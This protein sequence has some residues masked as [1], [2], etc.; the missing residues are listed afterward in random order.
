MKRLN[1][2]MAALMVATLS[3]AACSKDAT[4]EKPGPEPGPEQPVEKELTFEAVV[5]ETTRTSAFINVT[6][7]DLE[8]DYLAVVYP[9]ATVEQ[10]ATDAELIVK[11]GSFIVGKE[12]RDILWPPMCMVTSVIKNP[13]IKHREGGFIYEGDKLLVHF[14]SYDVDRTM[15][16]LESYIGSQ[17]DILSSKVADVNTNDSIPEI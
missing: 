3:F 2:L 4:T 9:A 13:D 14:I 15:H 1:W 8:A 12:I 10:C 5:G 6:P 11:R 7:S 16:E 17:N